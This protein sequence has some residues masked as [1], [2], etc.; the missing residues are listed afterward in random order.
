MVRSA[1][2]LVIVVCAVV[3]AACTPAFVSGPGGS[4]AA[5][6]AERLLAR[7]WSD[8]RSANFRVLSDGTDAQVRALI[9]DLERFRPIA[10]AVLGQPA[11]SPEPLLVIAPRDQASFA[12]FVPSRTVA[13]LFSRGLRG[14]VLLVNLAARVA[15]LDGPRAGVRSVA[16]HEYVHAV[17]ADLPGPPVPLWY[18][19]GTAEYLST[20][21]IDR[22]GV[23]IGAAI[24]G[25]VRNLLV[26]RRLG[27]DALLRARPDAR[28]Y[29]R[30]AD[31]VDFHAHAWLLVHYLHSRPD[32]ARVLDRYKALR[33]AGLDETAAIEDA[34]GRSAA[35]VQGDLL[36]YVRGRDFQTRHVPIAVPERVAITRTGTLSAADMLVQLALF[37]MTDRR[38]FARSEAV[39]D[40]AL[41]LEPEHVAA[42]A[43]L[44]RLRVHQDRLDDALALADRAVALDPNA[45]TA[46]LARAE[47][48]AQQ[49]DRAPSADRDPLLA[50]ALDAA[51]RADARQ[52]HLVEPKLVI[53]L[54]YLHGDYGDTPELLREGLAAFSTARR[55]TPQN[56]EIAYLYGALLERAG[57]WEA[58]AAQYREAARWAHAPRTRE[59]AARRL[60]LAGR[61]P[62]DADDMPSMTDMVPAPPLT[63][64]GGIFCPLSPRT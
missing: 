46:L 56:A 62:M 10:R 58:A 38:A 30:A 17:I 54:I 41:A 63:A 16:Q 25:R 45:A 32:A 49:A 44:A 23:V 64:R 31:G 13:G 11:L 59:L 9:T 20:A 57:A 33:R 21:R 7:P 28:D 40:R 8:H 15:G 36:A 5:G 50:A 37:Q 3:A 42:L 26:G 60:A 22:S 35:G 55:L 34:L 24:P 29:G 4:S 48:L 1:R 51:R 18:N 14:D 52:P 27:L 53:G 61:A 19:E 39:L 2:L 6:D 12:V 47:A 43:A